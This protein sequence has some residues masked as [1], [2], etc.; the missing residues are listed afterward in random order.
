MGKRNPQNPQEI[1]RR[2]AAGHDRAQEIAREIGE[3]V[4]TGADVEALR[5]ER[6]RLREELEDMYSALRVLDSRQLARRLLGGT[7]PRIMAL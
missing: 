2:I 3:S 6:R 7:P 1:R 4:L 5:E